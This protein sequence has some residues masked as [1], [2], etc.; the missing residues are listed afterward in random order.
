MAERVGFEPTVPVKAQQ[1]SRLPDS[2]TL[3]PLREFSIIR[4]WTQ[5]YQVRLLFSSQLKEGPQQFQAFFS[6]YAGHVFDPVV[7]FAALADTEMGVD[8]AK[9][10]VM[11][12]KYDTADAGGH[13][14]PGAHG[15]R[16]ERR[17]NGCTT[18]PVIVD[19]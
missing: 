2:T 7:E 17:I 8:R 16:L 5:K 12:P 4:V 13:E 3:A 9:S 6:H 1:F 11:R 18:K 14:C 10:N 15:T 19:L